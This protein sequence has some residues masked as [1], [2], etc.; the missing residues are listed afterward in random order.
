MKIVFDINHPAHINFFKN[1]IYELKREGHRIIIF[2]LRRGRVPHILKHEFRDFEIYIVGKHTGSFYSILFEA[3]LFKFFKL[4]WFVIK[5]KPDVGLSVGGFILG[6]CMKLIGKKNYQFDD[7]P[8]SSQ[9]IFLEKLTATEVHVPK[10]VSLSKHFK[11]FNALKEWAYLSPTYFHPEVDILKKYGLFESK[12]IFIREVSSGSLNYKNRG[13]YSVASFA[14]KIDCH[15]IKVLFSLED[16]SSFHLYPTEWVL[17]S[18]PVEHIHSL[19]YFSLLV[20][21][22]GDSMAREGALLGRPSIYCGKRKMKANEV[23]LNKH[24]LFQIEPNKVPDF[25]EKLL[26]QEIGV[27]NR[28]EFRNSLLNEWDDINS[29]IINLLSK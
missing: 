5:I 1:A 29:H 3:N 22:S 17:L 14:N 11:T 10:E 24:M 9:N 13:D 12:F 6:F 21:S 4:F 15:R 23:L 7:D 16:K 25:V 2:G 8:E 20:I 26:N 28:D 27:K 18:E 19:I